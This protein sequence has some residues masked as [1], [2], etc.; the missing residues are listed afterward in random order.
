MLWFVPSAL[1][2]TGDVMFQAV[3]LDLQR[4]VEGSIQLLHGH[5]DGTLNGNIHMTI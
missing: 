5:F 2:V 1:G 4:V 3:L